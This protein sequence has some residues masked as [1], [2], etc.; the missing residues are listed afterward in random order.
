[1]EGEEAEERREMRGNVQEGI[2]APDKKDLIKLTDIIKWTNQMPT[3]LCS[4]EVEVAFV[5]AV[6]GAIHRAAGP[7]LL[8]ECASL[9]G[10]ETGQAKITCGYGLPANVT[11]GTTCCS[12][13][14]DSQNAS[15]SA[16]WGG[17]DSH[18]R[19]DRTRAS[20]GCGEGSPE[21][22]LQ[23]QPQR[24]HPA[25]GTFCGVPLHLHWNL[26]SV[27]LL[28]RVCF[29]SV[30]TPTVYSVCARPPPPAHALGS[31]RYQ[32]SATRRIISRNS[33]VVPR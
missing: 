22:L 17:R 29:F 10:C 20:W 9:Q 16:R 18:G 32:S 25:R 24:S 15:V 19:A 6:D 14:W 4:A 23:E 1:M 27:I 8:K 30:A 7:A 2:L 5:I 13:M 12:S 11:I 3:G 26:R 31:S 28:T 33:E 21:V